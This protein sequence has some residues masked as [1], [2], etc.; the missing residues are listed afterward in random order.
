VGNMDRD[1][2]APDRKPWKGAV[3]MVMSLQIVEEE[4]KCLANGATFSG[5]FGWGDICYFESFSYVNL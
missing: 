2:L 1:F 4:G 3:N 5:I